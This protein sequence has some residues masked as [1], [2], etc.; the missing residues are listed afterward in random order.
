MKRVGRRKY[1]LVKMM[2]MMETRQKEIE[3][4]LIEAY[5]EDFEERMSDIVQ[6]ICFGCIVSHPSQKNHD[7]CLMMSE[8][9]R[10][11]ACWREFLRTVRHDLV[12]EAWI[13]R[14]PGD[15]DYDEMKGL[16]NYEYRVKYWLSKREDAIKQNL[17]RRYEQRRRH[18]MDTTTAAVVEA[19]TT[20]ATPATV[21]TTMTTTAIENFIHE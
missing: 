12:T 8:E 4:A 17:L 11:D 21:A 19:G 9:D 18:I 14:L 6:N 15:V 5:T 13:D 3:S 1:V 16:M 10:V 2:M 20:G 7:V